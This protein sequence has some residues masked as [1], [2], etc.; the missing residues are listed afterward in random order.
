MPDVIMRRMSY[1]NC[2]LFCSYYIVITRDQMLILL[3]VS[4]VQVYVVDFKHS[5]YDQRKLVHIS[6]LILF[7]LSFVFHWLNPIL[8]G[9]I[10][11]TLILWL[12]IVRHFVTSPVNIKPCSVRYDVPQLTL[13]SCS[14][15]FVNFNS[16]V[17]YNYTWLQPS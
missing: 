9:I 16:H 7:I 15:S 2:K 12:C 13:W 6:E 3:T 14:Q 10:F 1:C 8:L 11:D 17:L 4:S 5:K